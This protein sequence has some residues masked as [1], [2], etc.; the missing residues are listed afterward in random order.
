MKI[1]MNPSYAAQD[2]AW[3]IHCGEK[4]PCF[5]NPKRLETIAECLQA[6]GLA[7]FETP[8][9]FGL[10]PILRVHT[11]DYVT[12]LQTIWDDWTET[13]H[14]GQIIPYVW[15]TPGLK[16]LKHPNLNAKVGQYAFP[17]IHRSSPARGKPPMVAPSAP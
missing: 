16:R 1:V 6:R 11:P 7:P 17:P 5:E 12:F 10:D 2:G 13:G 14:T 9:D 3:E 15:P 4:V 8:E